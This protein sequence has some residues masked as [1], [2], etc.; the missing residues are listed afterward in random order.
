MTYKISR[1]KHPNFCFE[2]EISM[3]REN[4]NLV[5]ILVQNFPIMHV[6]VVFLIVP[7]FHE[8]HPTFVLFFTRD[9]LKDANEVQIVAQRLKICTKTNNKD[10][11]VTHTTI[12][13]QKN[14][15]KERIFKSSV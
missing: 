11:Q 6:L 15:Y 10:S 2:D 14:G 9:S 3:I 8:Y 7:H 4:H 5:L 13:N 12:A 1:K